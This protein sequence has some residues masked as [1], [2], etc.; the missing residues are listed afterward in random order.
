[1][2]KVIIV[3]DEKQILESTAKKISE[4]DGFRILGKFASALF[5]YEQILILE[6]DVVI[7]D[8][9]MPVM[10]GIELAAK[11]KNKK[12]HIKFVFLTAHRKYAV[13]A[14]QLDALHYIIKPVFKEDLEIVL[15][16]ALRLKIIDET[17][18]YKK[19]KIFVFGQF[20]VVNSN[21]NR[22]SWQTLK[23]EELFALLLMHR[24][25]GIDR[26]QLVHELWDMEEVK[27]PLQ[28]LYSAINRLRKTFENY[29]LPFKIK[30]KN[31]IYTLEI[32]E[33]YF[34]YEIYKNYSKIYKNIDITNENLEIYEKIIGIYAGN[35][36]GF[37]VYQWSL[38]EVESLENLNDKFIEKLRS[39]YIRENMKTKL[40]LLDIKIRSKKDLFM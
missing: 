4:I 35:I 1:M 37:K 33:T 15:K 25:N 16:R 29:N 23:V 11:V 40:K 18:D 14:F 22:V 28:N 19:N 6:P 21:N 3:D 5:A 38:Y 26:W 13:E 7:T 2:V 17:V 36:F 20:T 8:I 30:I 9:K 24:E 27:D 34:D 10:S 31:G 32:S 12:G 39:F